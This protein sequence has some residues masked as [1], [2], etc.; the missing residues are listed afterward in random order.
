MANRA[1]DAE[2]RARELAALELLSQGAGSA[3]A[4]AEM[5][6]RYGCSL[7][8]AR[9]YVSVAA[10]ELCGPLTPAA[11]DSMAALT[12]HRLD[13]IAGRAAIDGETET[14]IKASRAHAT[15]LAQFRRA[16]TA[17]AGTRFRLPDKR[18]G[19]VET[20]PNDPEEL[21]F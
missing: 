5:A 7:R 6:A 8:Q 9:R 2:L 18:A 16:I 3:Y 12:L 13:A 1:G 4:A 21:P 10:L 14:A 17:P 20:D 19:P 11:L 15:A